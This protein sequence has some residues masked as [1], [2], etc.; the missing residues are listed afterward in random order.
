MI[1]SHYCLRNDVLKLYEEDNCVFG[2]FIPT[3]EQKL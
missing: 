2:L 3:L 1:I